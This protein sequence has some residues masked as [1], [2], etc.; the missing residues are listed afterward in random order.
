[1]PKHGLGAAKRRL[2][3][4]GELRVRPTARR[5]P[6]GGP[7]ACGPRALAECPLERH[8]R[9]GAQTDTRGKAGARTQNAT[10]GR[11]DTARSRCAARRMAGLHECPW[12]QPET[13]ANEV[14]G[15]PR[16]GGAFDSSA[17]QPKNATNRHTRL[18]Q[19]QPDVPASSVA[20]PNRL[21]RHANRRNNLC[22]PWRL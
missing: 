17:S 3:G 12:A 9:L 6:G 2:G 22:M 13:P 7:K 5:T 21:E 19:C 16:T 8:K 20:P 1:M 14:V 10:Q 11:Q 15:G 4:T 18:R